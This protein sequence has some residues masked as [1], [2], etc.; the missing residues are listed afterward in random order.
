MATQSMLDAI[1]AAI[2]SG[3]KV[4]QYNGKRVEY[5]DIDELLRARSVLVNQLAGGGRTGVLD[6]MTVAQFSRD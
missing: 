3:E 6:R 4:V 2:A 5:R 1:D